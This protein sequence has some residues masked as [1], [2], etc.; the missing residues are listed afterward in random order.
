MHNFHFRKTVTA[1]IALASVTLT[2]CLSWFGSENQETSEQ[3]AESKTIK[4]QKETTSKLAEIEARTAEQGKEN[5]MLKHELQTQQ[6]RIWELSK[7]LEN[8]SMKMRSGFSFSEEEIAA[9]QKQHKKTKELAKGSGAEADGSPSEQMEAP[10]KDESIAEAP[11]KKESSPKETT[12]LAESKMKLAEFGEAI[13]LLSKLQS[14][15]PG[16]EDGGRSLKLLA[17]CWIAVG[18]PQNALPLLRKMQTR[19]PE[20]PHRIEGKLI[21]AEAHER[22]G[23]KQRSQSLYREVLALAPAGEPAQRARKALARIREEN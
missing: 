1:A 3:G 17:Q 16:L 7:A 6:R 12:D 14:D 11:P 18:E 8:H 19:F 4:E 5:L 2:G 20:G 23:A 15:Q 10:S 13:P 22:L 9:L 21:E